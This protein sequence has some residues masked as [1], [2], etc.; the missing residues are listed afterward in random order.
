[1]SGQVTVM[2]FGGTSLSDSAA[3]E[4]VTNIVGSYHRVCS[5]V[6]IASAM[7]SVTDCLLKCMQFSENGNFERTT[8]VLEE[9]QRRHLQVTRL[10]RKSDAQLIQTFI[11]QRWLDLER[12]LKLVNEKG[13]SAKLSDDVLSYGELLC[14]RLLTAILQNH[15]LPAVYIDARRCIVT[16]QDHGR[17]KPLFEMTRRRTRNQIIPLL[18]SGKIPVL[19]GFIGSTRRSATT[20]LG[21]G[22]SDYTATLIGA[23]LNA[24]ETQIWTDVDGVL[25]ADPVLIQTARRIPIL[26]FAEAAELARFGA[27]VLHPKTIHPASESN[28]PVRVFNS[29]APE[30]PGTLICRRVNH[31]RSLIKALAHKTGLTTV[32]ITLKPGLNLESFKI[33]LSRINKQHRL[34]AEI[35]ATSESGILLALD[36]T[37]ALAEMVRSLSEFGSVSVSE[38]RAVVCC[39]G[40]SWLGTSENALDNLTALEPHVEWQRASAV[41]V[42]AEIPENRVGVVVSRLHQRIFDAN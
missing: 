33:Q 6:V 25:T 8:E 10:L 34:F 16:N 4:R 7:S 28:V 19:G 41:S 15:G 20:T 38:R 24:R 2:K 22:G 35:L 32:R 27:K 39:V 13:A 31:H 40:E 37:D 36:R 1:M 3:F 11:R 12:L 29:Q 17:A 9:Q 21:R 5:L 42:I 26:S 30:F 23:A 18:R 14:S